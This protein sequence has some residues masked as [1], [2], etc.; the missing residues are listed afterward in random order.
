M[1]ALGL[2]AWAGAEVDRG[3]DGTERTLQ[4]T[5][6]AAAEA[7]AEEADMERCERVLRAAAA[8]II[9]S[10]LVYD[11]RTCERERVDSISRSEEAMQKFDA[12]RR[13]EAASRSSERAGL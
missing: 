1:L 13:A 12:E 9:L 6:R 10:P 2:A 11:I 4:R 7:A 5:A 8:S 3:A